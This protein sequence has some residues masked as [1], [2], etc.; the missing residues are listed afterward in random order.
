MSEQLQLSVKDDPDPLPGETTHENLTT[1]DDIVDLSNYTS[2]ILDDPKR[3]TGVQTE[4]RALGNGG[5]LERHIG[6]GSWVF[7]YKDAHEGQ[8]YSWRLTDSSSVWAKKFTKSA[9]EVRKQIES[10][11]VEDERN[12]VEAQPESARPRQKRI[13]GMFASRRARP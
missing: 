9:D 4:R 11:F 2:N 10:A 5:T 7:T 6:D 13:L 12:A 3:A 1:R 8:K